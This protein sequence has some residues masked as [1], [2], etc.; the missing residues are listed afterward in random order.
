[1]LQAERSLVRFQMRSLIF[2]VYLIPPA[3]VPLGFSQPLT[4]MS[5][6]YG[7]KSLGIKL[8]R[9]VRLTTSSPSVG[10]L[11]RHCEILNIS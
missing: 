5:R 8:S 2:S 9:C 3:A 4:E 10:R 11:S 1:M 7:K 6:G